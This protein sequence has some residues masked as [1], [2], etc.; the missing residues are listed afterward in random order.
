MKR[1]FLFG[2]FSL[3]LMNAYAQ[4]RPNRRPPPPPPPGDNQEMFERRGPRMQGEDRKER[5]ERIEVFKIQFITEKLELTPT[6]AESF[7]PVY[8]E[9]NKAVKEIAKTKSEDEI[10]FQE[11]ILVARKK[12]KTDL[13]PILK[14]DERV[15]EALKIEREFLNKIRFEMNKRR[16][17]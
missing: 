3:L 10:L 7:W 16:G 13:K 12:Y 14:S 4:P 9:Y 1:I 5:K 2:L 8:E 11:A 17:F 6:E 15:N